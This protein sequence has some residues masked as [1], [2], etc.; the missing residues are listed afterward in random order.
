MIS[1]V[2]KRQLFKGSMA[3]CVK[4]VCCAG[5]EI[6]VLRLLLAGSVDRTRTPFVGTF[7]PK[8]LFSSVGAFSSRLGGT[9]NLILSKTRTLKCTLPRGNRKLAF[10]SWSCSDVGLKSLCGQMLPVSRCQPRRFQCAAVGKEKMLQ[11]GASWPGK[12]H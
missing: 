8:R 11:G 10:S 1:A 3:A 4:A 9:Q 6:K 7:H 12:N 5:V 2:V